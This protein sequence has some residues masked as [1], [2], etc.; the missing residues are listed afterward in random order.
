M[1]LQRSLVL[2]LVLIAASA[3]VGVWAYRMLPQEA[4]VAVHFNLRGQP[5]AYA[6][7][8]SGLAVMPAIGLVVVVLL[9]YAPRWARG[10][11]ALVR[12]GGAYGIVLI[13]I[14]AMFLVGEAAIA[15]RALDPAF[16]VLRWLFLAVGI[17]TVVI[18]AVLGRIP[19]NRV[20]G[21]RTPWTLADEGV[22]I[23]THRF[24]G[25]LMTL[26]GVALAAVATLGA[27]HT[28]LFVALIVCVL[29][30]GVAGVIYARA[31]AGKPADG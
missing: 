1:R 19:P 31:I 11:E 7:K 6:P 16:D 18:G 22:W 14:A 4:E 29:G 20:V 12:A 15:M 23:R 21:I 27:D 10:G 3:A 2:A 26:A 25:R 9:A 8:W 30:P 28:D 24:T 5:N 13:G 17:L